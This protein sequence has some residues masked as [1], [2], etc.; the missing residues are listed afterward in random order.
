[1]RLPRCSARRSCKILPRRPSVCWPS[2]APSPDS[3]KRA[4]RISNRPLT[5]NTEVIPSGPE[6][7]EGES[8]DL[9]LVSAKSYE[10]TANSCVPLAT[11][12]WRLLY[13]FFGRVLHLQASRFDL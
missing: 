4:V 8:R 1:M 13:C 9:H 3:S 7:R 12:H 2:P 6:H 10:L 11:E 5:I